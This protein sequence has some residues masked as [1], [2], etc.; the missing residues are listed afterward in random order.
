ME[1][2]P[3]ASSFDEAYQ[4]VAETLNSVEDELTLIPFDLDNWRN[5][6][7]LYPPLPDSVRT[8]PSNPKVKRL[9]NLAHNTYI[10]ENGAIEIQN[11]SAVVEFSK[12]G[13]D[14]KG[15]WEV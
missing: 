6:G 14:A 4:L 11:I 12:P 7:R 3:A 5:D 1:R 13:K 9:R 10:A 15:V 8:V 2:S